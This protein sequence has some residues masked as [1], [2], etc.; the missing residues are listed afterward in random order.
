[1][2]ERLEELDEQNREAGS[3]FHALLSRLV[4]EVPALVGPVFDRILDDKTG[5]DAAELLE[6][7]SLIFDA[8]HPPRTP[9]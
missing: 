5:A 6:R 4:M 7:L 1:M 2:A 3:V 8:L 9:A